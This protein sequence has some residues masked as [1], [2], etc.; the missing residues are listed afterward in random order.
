MIDVGLLDK[1]FAQIVEHPETWN[2][3]H[4]H[5]TDEL[6]QTF[7]FAGHVAV[8]AGLQKPGPDADWSKWYVDPTY[9]LYADR[10]WDH[11]YWIPVSRFAREKLG[12]STRMAD[13]LFAGN[14]SLWGIRLGVG[15]LRVRAAF[16]RKDRADA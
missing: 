1:A 11:G 3:R 2:Q 15:Y 14:R 5:R 16:Q 8:L 13:Y 12:I 10:W 4:W 9:G 6:G 7:C